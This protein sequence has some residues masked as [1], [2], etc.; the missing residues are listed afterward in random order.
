MSDPKKDP[1][2]VRVP[3]TQ[4]D[5][6]VQRGVL[7]CHVDVDNVVATLTRDDKGK[8]FVLTHKKR[9]ATVKYE[10]VA[11]A[12]A[13]KV[14]VA[15]KSK[16][17]AAPKT[18]TV[19]LDTFPVKAIEEARSKLHTVGRLQFGHND[20]LVFGDAHSLVLRDLCQAVASDLS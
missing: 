8:R 6:P 12:L 13:L 4:H 2:M 1:V 16:K 9:C 14:L 18:V 5:K 10:D 3:Y 20:L 19:Q 11:D 15:P 17:K 7:V